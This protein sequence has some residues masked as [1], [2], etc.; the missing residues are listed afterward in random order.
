MKSVN[1]RSR[2]L[3][4]YIAEPD[5]DLIICRCEEITKGEIRRAVHDGMYTLTEIRRYLRTGMGLCQ[6]QTCSKLVKSIVSRELQIS[7]AE[8]EPATSRVP[9]RPI[10]MYLFANE[11][12]EDEADE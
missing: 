9:M 8:L 1:D 12:K 4:E 3:L 11:G 5:D 7:P 6:G 2:D 10:E